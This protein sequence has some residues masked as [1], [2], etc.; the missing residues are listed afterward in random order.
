M[1]VTGERTGQLA[2]MLSKVSA[3][4][5]EMHATSVGR[6]KTFIEPILIIMLTGIVAVIILSVIVPMFALYNSVGL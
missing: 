4:Y 1:I 2:E 6:L 3:F 5:Q